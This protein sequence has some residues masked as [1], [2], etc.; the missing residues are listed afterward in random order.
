MRIGIP[1]PEL[2][3]GEN[4]TSGLNNTKNDRLSGLGL[5]TCIAMIVI[6]VSVGKSRT[7][8]YMTK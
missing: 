5:L 6:T 8:L 2:K 3:F 1:I 7:T 4:P